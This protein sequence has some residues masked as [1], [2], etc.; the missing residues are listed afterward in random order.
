[1]ITNIKCRVTSQNKWLGIILCLFLASCA[2][3]PLPATALHYEVSCA[4]AESRNQLRQYFSTQGI[5]TADKTT[6]DN[7][8]FSILTEPLR[9]PTIG[10]IDKGID[11]R[12]TYELD[13]KPNE[14]ANTSIIDLTRV[15]V[16]SKGTRERDWHSEGDLEP[17]LQSEHQLTKAIQGICR[18]AQQ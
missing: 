16:E 10:K 5:R 18:A 4:P 7:K 3:A 15:T 12:I 13:I 14:N 8:S 6:P 2:T 17:P 1:M 11:R 9:E